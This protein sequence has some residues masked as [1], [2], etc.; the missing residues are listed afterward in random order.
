MEN[1]QHVYKVTLSFGVHDV[2]K[3]IL[4]GCAN[5]FLTKLR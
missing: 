3:D 1:N 5:Q 4:M 2:F